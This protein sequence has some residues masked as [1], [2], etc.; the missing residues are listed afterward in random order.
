MKIDFLFNRDITN[1]IL[2]NVAK[3]FTGPIT[4]ILIPL[5][6][7]KET[8]GYWYTFAS[9]SALSIFADLGFT[10]IVIQFAA[11]EFAHLKFSANGQFE[12]EEIY[13]NRIASFFR[14]I[15]KWALMVVIFTFPIIFIIGFFIIRG[16]AS[17][18][19][20]TLPWT[21]YVL[22]SG[23]IF[24]VN[25]ILA[26]F[27]GCGN[28][29]K[30]QKI[31][32]LT[33]IGYF[34]VTTICLISGLN[35]YSLALG[36]TINGLLLLAFSAYYFSTPI[37]QLLYVKIIRYGWHKEVFNL[38]WKYAI[39][40]SSGYF[41]FQLFTPVAF[42]FYGA[43]VAGQVGITLT[44]ITAIFSFSTI[45]MYVVIPKINMYVSLKQWEQLNIL[46]KKQSKR[47][48]L[49][50]LIGGFTCLLILNAIPISWGYKER[51]LP[52]LNVA[53]LLI[54]WLSQVFVHCWAIYLRSNKEEPLV[55]VTLF[56]GIYVGISTIII[57][58]ILPYNY[59][60]AGFISSYLFI[61]PWVYS[62]FRKKLQVSSTI[63]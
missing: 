42:K 35:L 48:Y 41:I 15:S 3:L 36:A 1:T 34:V 9:L 25:I 31:R 60:F 7:T 57:A 58:I 45:W 19:N 50:F 46:F 10:S 32:F 47:T 59:L 53:L 62:I 24:F 2:A 11:H 33:T 54:G 55:I 27:E 30:V 49:T 43:E 52:T 4:M 51:F 14:F 12:G 40:W 17:K 61:I 5:F 8:Q 21:I 28:I 37:F 39:S 18:I 16:D 6:L 29:A 13:F 20:W 63:S 22:S 44:M 38:L 56:E 26:F 23:I